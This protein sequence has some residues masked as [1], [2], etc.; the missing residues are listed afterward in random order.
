MRVETKSSDDV[1]LLI[2]VSIQYQY[3]PENTYNAFYK[4]SN[5]RE[6]L[7]AYVFDV[8]RATV[9]KIPLNEV[10]TMKARK[11]KRVFFYPRAPTSVAQKAKKT[12]QKKLTFDAGPNRRGRQGGAHQVDDG[13][14]FYLFSK[15]EREERARREREREAPKQEEREERL[16]NSSPCLK[17][18]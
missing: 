12:P 14:F 2:V 17:Q 9:P 15:E 11:Q 4:L 10:F 7:S 6:Q 8:V 1:F 13:A 18:N 16:P 5:L 3:D